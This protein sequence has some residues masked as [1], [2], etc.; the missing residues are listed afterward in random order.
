[1]CLNVN[2]KAG[3]LKVYFSTK[4][5]VIFWVLNEKNYVLLP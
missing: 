3:K 5:A 1:M 4:K 2:E